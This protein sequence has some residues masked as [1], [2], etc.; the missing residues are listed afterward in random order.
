MDNEKKHARA[1]WSGKWAFV[2]AG[3]VI[4]C[5]VSIAMPRAMRKSLEED[6]AKAD[7]KKK[8]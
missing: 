7:T 8:K 6:R 3:A 1:S 5:Y 2:L 4:Q